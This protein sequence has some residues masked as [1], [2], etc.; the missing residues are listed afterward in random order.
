MKELIDF[1]IKH[2]WTEKD[3]TGFHWFEDEDDGDLMWGPNKN[4]RLT[5]S[6]GVM[7]DIGTSWVHFAHFGDWQ[8]DTNFPCV[9]C[10]DTRIEFRMPG[11]EPKTVQ[12][13]FRGF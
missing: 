2:G 8:F 7:I 11:D 10:S 9:D 5:N 1:L 12:R 13:K 6:K 4:G 3:I